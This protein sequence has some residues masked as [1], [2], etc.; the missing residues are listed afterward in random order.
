MKILQTYGIPCILKWAKVFRPNKIR[1]FNRKT[2]AHRYEAFLFLSCMVSTYMAETDLS[3]K[4]TIQ[5]LKA[6]MTFQTSLPENQNLLRNILLFSFTPP[7]Y[8]F[9]DFFFYF[10]LQNWFMYNKFHA[11]TINFITSCFYSI[12]CIKH[13]FCIPLNT[14]HYATKMR[15]TR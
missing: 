2:L 6:C 11:T 3:C 13:F 14:L 7:V 10:Y 9:I 15:Y 8:V 1:Q 5:C 4:W 12:L